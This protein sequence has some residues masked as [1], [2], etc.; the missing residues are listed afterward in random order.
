MSAI[1]VGYLVGLFGGISP[2]PL[3]VALVER[4]GEPRR[5][6]LLHLVVCVALGLG[7]GPLLRVAAE[8]PSRRIA[9]A[10]AYVAF[11]IVLSVRHLRR[12]A[13]RKLAGVELATKWILVVGFAAWTGLVG[14]DLAS[15]LGFAAGVWGGVATWFG[16]LAFL[17]GR[18]KARHIDAWL[19]ACTA[20]V[21]GVLIVAGIYAAREFSKT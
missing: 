15:G 6:M 7:A 3:A 13:P 12:G 14:H 10:L 1:L 16:A 9:L 11:G 20:V 17:G 19:R 2:G 18:L 4:S 5:A 21:A 8:T